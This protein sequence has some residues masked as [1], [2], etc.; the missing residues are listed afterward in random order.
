MMSIEK[1]VR[2]IE[3][4]PNDEGTGPSIS[5]RRI[6]DRLHDMVIYLIGLTSQS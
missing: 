5:V 4:R 1:Q 2:L 3:E 6:A